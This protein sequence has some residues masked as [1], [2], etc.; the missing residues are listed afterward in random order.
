MYLLIKHIHVASVVISLA[1]FVARGA[2]MVAASP[3]LRTRFVRIAPHIVDTVLLASAIWLAWSLKQYPFVYGWLT[4][5]VAG[6]V[7]YIGFGTL[8][9]QRGRTLEIRLIFFVLAL[10]AA[11]YV[12]A[13]A[14]TRNPAVALDWIR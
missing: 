9:L 6:L 5:K 12:V 3:L 2:L 8:A 1:G 10:L 7:A 4:A 13:V 11:A 14:L